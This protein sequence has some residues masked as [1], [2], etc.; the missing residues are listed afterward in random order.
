MSNVLRLPDF[1][2]VGAMKAGTTRLHH[3]LAAHPDIGVPAMKETDFFVPELNRGRTLAWYGAQFPSAPVVGEVSPAYAK[4][5]LYPGTAAR[6][7]RYVPRVKVIYLTRDPVARALSEYRHKRAA[8]YLPEPEVRDPEVFARLVDASLYHRQISQYLEVMPRERV[9]V[10]EAEQLEA[11]ITRSRL[12]RF[13]GVADCWPT[14][15]GHGNAG[16]NVAQLP[17]WYWRARELSAAR[18][19]RGALPEPIK[20]LLRGGARKLGRV[21]PGPI[22]ADLVPRIRDAIA[23]DQERFRAMDLSEPVVPPALSVNA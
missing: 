16:E 9:L 21:A 10:I 15:R 17:G 6:I 14:P 23:G 22:P 11:G 5:R 3:V 18:D 8:G 19:L 4:A 7:L 20:D 13:L 12:A 1:I 2:V